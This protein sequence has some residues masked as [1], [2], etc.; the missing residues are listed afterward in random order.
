MLWG[1]K[2]GP[3]MAP[4]NWHKEGQE[5]QEEPLQCSQWAGG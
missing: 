1:E 4:I 2:R 5:A 3:F